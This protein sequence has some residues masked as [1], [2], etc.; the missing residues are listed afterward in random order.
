MK[1]RDRLKL[2]SSFLL[3]PLFRE[4]EVEKRS[5]EGVESARDEAMVEEEIDKRSDCEC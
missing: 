3:K 1:T 5:R 4:S 2:L